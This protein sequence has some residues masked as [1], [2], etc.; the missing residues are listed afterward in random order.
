MATAEKPIWFQSSREQLDALLLEVCDGLQL[1]PSRHELAVER[2]GTVNEILEK[3]GSPFR[4][5]RPRIFPQGSMA[6]GTTCKPVEGP[7]D[8]DFV[9]QIDAPHW[10]WHP[11]AGLSALYEC[12]S[13]NETY[14]KM[15]SLKNRVVRLTYADEFYMDILPAYTDLSSGG[16]CIL[17]PD[18]ARVSL[19]PS[20]PEGFILW[21]RNRC[22]TRTRRVMEKAK[23]VP[24]QEAVHEKEPLQLAVQLL[25]R[26][27]DLAFAEECL[28]PFSK[29]SERG[30]TR[31]R[32]RIT[33]S[34]LEFEDCRRSGPS[35][36]PVGVKRTKNWSA[37]SANTFE[38]RSSSERNACRKREKQV[39][40]PSDRQAPSPDL[41]A[42]SRESVQTCFTAMR[43]FIREKFL[44]AMQQDQFVRSRFPHFRRTTNRGDRIKWRGTLQPSPRSDLYEVEIVYEIPCRPHIQVVTPRLTTWGDLK[45]Q[46]HTFRDGSL[47][48]HQA[49]EWHGNKLIAETIIPWT[50]LWLAFYETWLETGCWLGE[51]THPDLPEHSP[52]GEIV[53]AAA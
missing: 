16:T 31:I 15:I 9:L 43:R 14:R 12:L 24:A 5:L 37:Y 32:R 36:W 49:H 27:R 41:P 44:T 8:L 13:S 20:N 39:H 50:C 45:R 46:P 53:G 21:F 48:V 1:R 51:G 52:F 40:S 18:R 4:F 10:R 2:Y 6:L 7:H 25:K 22:L 30:G 3:A 26:W 35:S 17:V 33:H 11:L 29:T 23:P 38:R 47:C 42:A 19:C 34:K 28:A